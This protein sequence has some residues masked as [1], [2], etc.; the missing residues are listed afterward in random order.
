MGLTKLCLSCCYWQPFL[1]SCQQNFYKIHFVCFMCLI[2]TKIVLFMVN[3]LLCN[4]YTYP[5]SFVSP[6]ICLCIYVYIYIVVSIYLLPPSCLSS[7][8]SFM[9][10]FIYISIYE[11]IYLY[12]HLY[13]FVFYLH[14]HLSICLF[15]AYLNFYPYFIIFPSFLLGSETSVI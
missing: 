14:N 12:L 9:F 15:H 4:I 13:L 3:R 6:S 5:S 11:H 2:F 7:I 8:H 1:S 10:L